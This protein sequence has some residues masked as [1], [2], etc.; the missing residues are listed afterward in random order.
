M[1][2]YSK[3]KFALLDIMQCLVHFQF[4]KVSLYFASDMINL[5]CHS[6]LLLSKFPSVNLTVLFLEYFTF[7]CHWLVYSSWR[8][9]LW[10][11]DI[12]LYTQACGIRLIVLKPDVKMVLKQR[13]SITRLPGPHWPYVHGTSDSRISSVNY[14]CMKSHDKDYL[15][16]N[17][18]HNDKLGDSC[19][20][21]RTQ[22]VGTCPL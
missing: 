15:L 21:I 9:W 2:I 3:A 7:S 1:H 12:D 13:V 8:R 11:F 17:R 5:N 20:A 18:K 22:K 4:C 19:I 10:I 14:F 6:C 16:R